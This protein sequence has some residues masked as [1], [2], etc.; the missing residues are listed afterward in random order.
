MIF[1]PMNFS[2]FLA[3]GISIW[4]QFKVKGNIKKWSMALFEL[5]KFVMIFIQGNQEE[6]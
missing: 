2:I 6:E 4:A 3:L 5:I 1:H